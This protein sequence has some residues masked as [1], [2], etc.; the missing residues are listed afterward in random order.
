MINM[1]TN[2]NAYLGAKW[3]LRLIHSR[4]LQVRNVLRVVHQ[5]TGKQHLV[6]LL[7]NKSYVCDCAMGMNLGIPCRHYFSVLT[8][9]RE[10]RFHISVVRSRWLQDHRLDTSTIEAVAPNEVHATPLPSR[11]TLRNPATSIISNPLHIPP[12]TREHLQPPTQTLPA[13]E[14]FHETQAA[15][16]QLISS[17]NTQEELDDL[18]GRLEEVR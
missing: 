15:M 13:R 18:L 5:G 3:V 11:K 17:V 16:R 1:F 12:N 10:F 4:G 2:D 7:D 14:V 8:S 9:V 6:A